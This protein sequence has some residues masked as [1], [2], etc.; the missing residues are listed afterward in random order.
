TRST[1]PLSLHDALPIFRIAMPLARPA[2]AVGTSL[3]LMETLNDIGASE[4]L[5][6]RTLTLSVYST[7]VNQSDLPGSA[8]IALFM[9]LVVL[10][11]SEEHTSELQSRENLV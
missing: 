2:I 8:G 4:F 7:W 6:I 5:G 10:L 3:A 9:L 11:R 1:S